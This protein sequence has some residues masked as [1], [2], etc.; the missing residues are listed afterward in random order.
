MT[1]Q[2]E[3][4]LKKSHNSDTFD[5]LGYEDNSVL[6]KYKKYVFTPENK[7]SLLSPEKTAE[8]IVQWALEH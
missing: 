6:E 1:S 2:E 4:P 3:V 5:S 8:K 7:D